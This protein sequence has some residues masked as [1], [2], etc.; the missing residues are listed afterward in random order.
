MMAKRGW[1]RILESVIAVLIMA[2]VLIVIYTNKPVAISYSDYVS[3]LE[4]NLLDNIGSN[5][6]LRA[7]VL[8]SNTS[9]LK[10]YI[11]ANIPSNFN[12][13]VVVCNLDQSSNCIISISSSKEVFVEG[14]MI[15]ANLTKYDPKLV[16]IY[17]WEK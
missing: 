13:D 16:R 12:S 17:V 1:M 2:S 6:S 5:E 11:V 14:R 8:D 15:S 10:N 3:N 9:F 4:I 7:A